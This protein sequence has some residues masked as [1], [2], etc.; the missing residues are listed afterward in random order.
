M[1]LIAL[2]CQH[3]GAPLEV[4]AERPVIGRAEREV[5]AEWKAYGFGSLKLAGGASGFVIRTGIA[6]RSDTLVNGAPQ[7]RQVVRW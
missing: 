1:K 5:R 4:T 2:N 7:Q 6:V 3:C